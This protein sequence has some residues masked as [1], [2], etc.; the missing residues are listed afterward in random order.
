MEETGTGKTGID[1]IDRMMEE[2]KELDQKI[3]KAQAKLK[4]W[5]MPKKNGE[6]PAL[7]YDLLLAQVTAMSTYSNILLMRVNQARLMNDFATIGQF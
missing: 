5:D 3:E 1:F 7:T 4:E 2:G 6:V